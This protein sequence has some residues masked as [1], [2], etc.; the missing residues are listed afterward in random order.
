M[1]LYIYSTPFGEKGIVYADYDFEAESLV[2]DYYRVECKGI[3]LK[4]V[5][6]L[7]EDLKE[8]SKQGVIAFF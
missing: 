7:E 8:Y 5:K 4:Q 3:E 6:N 1:G 2:A